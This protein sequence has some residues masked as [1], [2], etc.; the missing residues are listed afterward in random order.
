MTA[1]VVTSVAAA[2]A[3]IVAFLA[4]R[5]AVPGGS[6]PAVA[7]HAAPKRPSLHAAPA[8]DLAV[9]N[10]D[11]VRRLPGPLADELLPAGRPG[12]VIFLKAD[13]DCSKGFAGMVSAVAAH[14][15]EHAKFTAVIEGTEADADAFATETGL[16]IPHV[17]QL[18]SGLAR[19]W[20]VRKAGCFA[21]VDPDGVVS[22]L[23]S[24]V[25]R[26]GFR[27]LARRLGVEPPLPE[28]LLAG[29]PG[30]ATAGCPL[31]YAEPATTSAGPAAE[32]STETS[33]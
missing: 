7:E 29:I 15:G 17:A 25:S 13:C 28:E 33:P 26:Q 27:D 16:M 5:T 24:G 8:G 31:G 4:V 20:G 9:L 22:G 10:A 19:D 32:S 6:R 3:V 23:W 2:A 21:V 11:V 12:V 18:A 14:L 1:R 30:A